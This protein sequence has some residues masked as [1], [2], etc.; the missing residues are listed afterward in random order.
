MTNYRDKFDLL[1]T[2]YFILNINVSEEVPEDIHIK[3]AEAAE[4][5][6]DVFKSSEEYKE[7]AMFDAGFDLYTVS[8]KSIE[9]N[10]Y[11]N[12]INHKINCSMVFVDGNES[13]HCGY[14]LYPRSSMGS[15]TPL[16]LSNSVGVMDSGYRGDAI[17]CVDN[18]S[19]DFYEIKKG[20][21]LVQICSPNICYPIIVNIVN[22]K[23]KLDDP[24]QTRQSLNS[25]GGGGFGSS[26]R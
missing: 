25:R 22:S 9:M 1:P 10:K 17:A 13:M 2:Q 14:F 7:L 19:E 4:K 15:K 12:K 24:E 3:Y 21:R 26:G 6:N 18:T 11:S 23:T 8:D 20:D 5:N 16:R